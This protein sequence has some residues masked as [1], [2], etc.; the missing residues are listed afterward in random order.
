MPFEPALRPLGEHP[1]LDALGPLQHPPLVVAEL[2]GDH[3]AARRGGQGHR[4]PSQGEGALVKGAGSGSVVLRPATLLTPHT[5]NRLDCQVSREP[6]RTEVLVDQVVQLESAK[7]PLFL[8]NPQGVV[9]TL[10]K[11]PY[12]GLQRR[13]L[14]GG[15]LQGTAEG[16]RLHKG[17]IV[18]CE[19]RSG[20]PPHV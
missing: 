10:G 18:S 17:I 11:Q 7:L 12:R 4:L 8:S 6:H 2:H 13:R 19:R 9:A 1:A 20:A 15:G 14:F 5:A 3:Q 16:K